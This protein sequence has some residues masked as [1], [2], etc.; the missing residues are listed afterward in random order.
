MKPIIHIVSWDS[1]TSSFQG[2]IY[3]GDCIRNPSAVHPAQKYA[4]VDVAPAA[5]TRDLAEKR[6]KEWAEKIA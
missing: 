4:Y 3:D 6:A 2:F 1:I 5:A